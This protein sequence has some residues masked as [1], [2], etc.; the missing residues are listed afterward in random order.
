MGA[1]NGGR[2]P[3]SGAVYKNIYG[4]SV[5]GRPKSASRRFLLRQTSSADGWKLT[6]TEPDVL[7]KAHADYLTRGELPPHLQPKRSAALQGLTNKSI[8]QG[9]QGNRRVFDG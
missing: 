9:F 8:S 6:N 1:S 3:L 5:G 4:P 7:L 2:T